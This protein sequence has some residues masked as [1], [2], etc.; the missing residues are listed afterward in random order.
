M[1]L[2]GAND[3]VQSAQKEIEVQKLDCNADEHSKTPND[4]RVGTN[5]QSQN[6]L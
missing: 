2:F 4:R 5:I 6:T 3:K 1:K